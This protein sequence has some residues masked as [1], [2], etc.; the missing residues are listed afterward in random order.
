[1]WK[2]AL[3]QQSIDIGAVKRLLISRYGWARDDVEHEDPF[4]S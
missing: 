4:Q 3:R 2:L 1:M